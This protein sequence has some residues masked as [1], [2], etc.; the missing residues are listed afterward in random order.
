P[1]TVAMRIL[2]NPCNKVCG[3]CNAANPEWASVN[4]LVVI[5][6]ACAGHH[7]ALGTNVSKVR[8]MKLDNNVWTEPL[9]QVSG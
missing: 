4:L 5:C 3:D 6:Q 9:M 8:S 7:R 2:E 1:K